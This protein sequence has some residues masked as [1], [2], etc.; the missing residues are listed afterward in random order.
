MIQV[1]SQV[2]DQTS[3]ATTTRDQNALCKQVN[4]FI[5]NPSVLIVATDLRVALDSK[6]QLL[7]VV[8][9]EYNPKST[10]G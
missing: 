1:F 2:I 9:V 7:Y 4:D 8:K 5:K 10:G 6:T 3:A